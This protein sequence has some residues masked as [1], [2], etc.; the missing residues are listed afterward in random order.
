MPVAVLIN[1]IAGRRLTPADIRDRVELATRAIRSH[2]EEPVVH[3]TGA[4]GE[5]TS[6]ARAAVEAG[7]RLVVAWG[8]DGTVNEVASGLVHGPAA[9]GIVPAGSG[10]G[11]AREL[12]IPR[13]PERALARAL[14]A[15]ERLI[16]AGELGGRLFVNVAG[17]GFDAWIA[18]RF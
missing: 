17:V 10:N 5:G 12:G 14:E 6:R 9:L 3:V 13:W 16:D 18:R 7:A 8:G 2:G 4:P 1:P 11:L 15:P